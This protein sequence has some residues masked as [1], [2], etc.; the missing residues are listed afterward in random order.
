MVVA[1]TVVVEIAEVSFWPLRTCSI[2][3]DGG[4]YDGGRHTG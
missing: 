4:D 3:L 1:V 2:F